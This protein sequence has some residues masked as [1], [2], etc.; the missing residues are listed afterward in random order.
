VL[1]AIGSACI[2]VAF[3]QK[4][5]VVTT[6]EPGWHKIGDIT[7]SFK[8]QT[9]SIV[10]LGADEFTAIKLKVTDAPIH[11]SRLQVFYESG[12]MEEI[13]VASEL[14]KGSE[15]RTVN[16][17]YPGK[18]INKI[19]FAYRTVANNKGDKAEVELYGLKTNQ[20]MGDDAYRNDKGE[21][22]GDRIENKTEEANNEV[23]EDADK[24][25]DYVKDK[26]N[27]AGNGIS[28]AA[29]KVMASI[30]DQRYADK[31]GPHNETIF[32][33]NYGKFYYINNEGNKVYVTKLQLKDKKK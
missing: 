14:Q 28:E 6:N 27:D 29:A 4:P 21:T 17:K 20:P 10:V 32:I 1:L 24:T 8:N 25:G 5:A 13:E 22:P 7:A 30:T 18:D 33:D 11:I 2:N 26:S 15:T 31:V 23:R 16:L 19:Q 9:E 3:A 12:D